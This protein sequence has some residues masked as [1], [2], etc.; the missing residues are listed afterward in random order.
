[1]RISDWS[2][3]VCSSDL[4]IVQYGGQTPLKLARALEANGVP[5]IGTSPDSIDL[6]EDRERFQ[7]LVDKLGLR[8]P[9]NPTAR[10]AEQALALAVE[11]GYP[12]LVRPRYVLGRRA[13]E[14]VHADADLPTYMR[15]PAQSSSASLVLLAPF[16]DTA[17]HIAL[18]PLPHHPLP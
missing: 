17:V 11:S 10:S 4:V 1:M 2:S 13:L 12:L 14:R 9:P 16:R 8:Q 6:A 18:H 5:I 7:K 15:H 3:D